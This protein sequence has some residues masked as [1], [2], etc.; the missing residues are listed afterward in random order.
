MTPIVAPK[1]CEMCGALLEPG[2]T[3]RDDYHDRMVAWIGWL[4]QLYAHNGNYA[5]LLAQLIMF[6][7]DSLS[8]CA[9]R[10]GLSRQRAAQL[11]A[12]MERDH[13]HLAG[14]FTGRRPAVLG[15]A[16][17]REREQNEN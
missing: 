7:D 10:V 2:D 1:R 17:R 12:A 4:T 13:P 6:P 14:V 5:R 16:R 3:A 9:E 8:R 11:M 15:Q